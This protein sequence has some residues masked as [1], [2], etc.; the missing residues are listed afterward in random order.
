MASRIQLLG[1]AL[2]GHFMKT[3]L[4]AALIAVAAVGCTVDRGE[5]GTEKNP[6]K[7]FFVPSVE[8]QTIKDSS[9]EIKRLLEASTPYKYRIRIPE[10]YV[11]VVEAFG[12]KRVDVAALNTFGY[13]LAREKFGAEALVTV[14]RHGRS[15]YRSAFYTRTD[16]P[17]QSLSDVEGESIAFVDHA[18]ASG[19]LLPLKELRDRGIEPGNSVFAMSHDA[20]ISMI[21]QG[22]VAVGAAFYSPPQ[23]GEV[24]DAR[25][26]VRTQYPDVLDKIKI[27]HLTQDIPN[28]PIVFR[29][30][31]PEKMKEEIVTALLNLAETEEGKKA[32]F[33]MFGITELKRSSDSDYDGVI[34]MLSD[35][36][37]S[38]SE[39]VAPEKKK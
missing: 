4:F 12:A 34:K 18:S 29:K 11:A 8:S 26:F 10:S 30:D 22:R 35:L 24:Q 39:L 28:E 37:Q 27:L 33:E 16:G 23:D 17:V 25:R 9:S 21:Y 38:A 3:T 2:M 5:L 20:V 7:L 6:I 31:M 13:V 19:Y 32:L 1:G 36:G 15:T 14:I